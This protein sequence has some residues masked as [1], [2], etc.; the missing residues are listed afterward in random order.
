MV[1]VR[2]QACVRQ[3]P[4]SRHLLALPPTPLPGPQTLAATPARAASGS[5]Q[6]LQVPTEGELTQQLADVG[7]ARMPLALT[8]DSGPISGS[9]QPPRLPDPDSQPL[10]PEP[11]C[12]PAGRSHAQL[13]AMEG[14]LTKQLAHGDA[15][16]PEFTAAVLARLEGAKARAKLREIHADRLARHVAALEARADPADVR[17]VM[18]WDAPE[19]AEVCP[20]FTWLSGGASVR[21]ADDPCST[22]QLSRRGR[23]LQTC[24]LWW[25]G[26]RWPA[27]RC[28]LLSK[29]LGARRACQAAR[30]SCGS[31]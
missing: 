27:L 11:P 30:G 16:D 13:E 22:W 23:T 10:T 6:T 29:W 20:A 3:T 18:G 12:A 31:A 21:G 7:A 1:H 28:A 2:Q 26:T 15:A 25:A 14:E 24:G 8:R 17:A 5:S 9:S 4:W 19:G